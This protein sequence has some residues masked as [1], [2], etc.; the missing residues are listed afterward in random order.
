MSCLSNFD[1][2]MFDIACRVAQTSDFAKFHVGCVLVYKKHIIASAANGEKTHPIQKKFNRKYRNFNSTTNKFIEDKI[3]A[4]IA[5]L[6]KIPYPVAQEIDW[7][8]VSVYV[9]R[10]CSGRKQGFGNAR[11]CGACLAA[12]KE[13]GIKKIYYTSSIGYCLEELE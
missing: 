7:K 2:K 5:A 10:I 4:E 8:K 9:Y 11:P 12:L 6:S 1:Y 3:H 13:K